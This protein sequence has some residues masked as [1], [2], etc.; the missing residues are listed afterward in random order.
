MSRQVRKGPLARQAGFRETGNQMHVSA[1]SLNA[2]WPPTKYDR[3][4]E[5]EN[6]FEAVFGIL[7]RTNSFLL[8]CKSINSDQ[9]A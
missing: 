7:S 2:L 3:S 1:V 5:W 4:R 6:V 9:N 8:R